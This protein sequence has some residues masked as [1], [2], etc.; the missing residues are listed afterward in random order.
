MSEIPVVAITATDDALR[1]ALAGVF[2]Q[3]GWEA[4]VLGSGDAAAGI[5]QLHQK[6]GRVDAWVY[7]PPTFGGAASPSSESDDPVAILEAGGGAVRTIMRSQSRGGAVVVYVS[8]EAVSVGTESPRVASVHAALLGAVR[9][10]GIAWAQQS[11]RVNAILAPL[12]S[13]FARVHPTRYPLRRLAT[14]EDLAWP[15]VFLASDESS[16]MTAE[17]LRVDGGFLCHHYF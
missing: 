7:V 13:A 5:N 16:Y 6:R 17:A 14:P 12:G 3:A 2:R 11:V 4:T 1:G 9:A 10:L 15:A 8:V